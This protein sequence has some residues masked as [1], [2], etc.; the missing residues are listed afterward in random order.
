MMTTATPKLNL[1]PE[2]YN[3]VQLSNFLHLY[4]D[5]TWY[6]IL[7]GS[8]ISFLAVFA[9]RLGGTAWQLGLLTAGPALVNVLFTIPAGRWLQKRNLGPAVTT[10]AALH[11]LGYLILTPLPLLLPTLLLPETV[12]IW[13]I[14]ILTLLM[15]IPGTAL[16]VGF[17]AALAAT[18]PEEA[19]G[20]VVGRRNAMLGATIMLSFMG[21]GWILGRLPF[22]WG[23]VVVFGLG[24]LGAALSTFHI[25]RLRVPPAPQFQYRPIRDKAQPGRMM[26][27]AGSVSHRLTV[28]T[29][30]WL[31]WPRQG[32]TSLGQIPRRYWQMM[33]AYFMFHFAQFL[34]AA[35]FP[36]FWVREA[37]LNDEQISWINALFYLVMLIT[38]PLLGPLTRKLGNHHL[39]VGSA[40]LLSSYPLFTGIAN[41]IT[42]LFVAAILGGAAWAILSGALVNR[43]LEF[44]PGDQRPSHLALYNMALNLATLGGVLLGPVL[45]QITGLREALLIIAGLRVVSGFM[46]ARWG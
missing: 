25:S 46:L 9:A 34:P 17:N 5:V 22:E 2:A 42:L 15:A 7:Y 6:G 27:A 32:D 39:N 11:R 31:H 8:A 37:H 28:A 13:V 18:V 20:K 23:Y 26:G 3:A 41:N 14:L 43:L 4:G 45:S 30:L 40:I 16:A 36:I 24:A 19:R 29:R 44:I 33:G 10:A 12:Q 35:L 1:N 21:S 38:S